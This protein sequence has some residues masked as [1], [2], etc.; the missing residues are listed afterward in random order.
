MSQDLTAKNLE[1]AWK[2]ELDVLKKKYDRQA[3]AVHRRNELI[4]KNQDKIKNLM[5]NFTSQKNSQENVQTILSPILKEQQKLFKQL[6]CLETKVGKQIEDNKGDDQVQN[7]LEMFLL[8]N[9][10]NTQISLLDQEI[11]EI[12]QALDP[13]KEDTFDMQKGSSRNH[14]DDQYLFIDR[15]ALN[16]RLPHSKDQQSLSS[17]ADSV[18]TLDNEVQNNLSQIGTTQKLDKQIE[19]AQNNNEKDGGQRKKQINQEQNPYNV[20]ANVKS[21]G[22]NVFDDLTPAAGGSNLFGG[23]SSSSGGSLFNTQSSTNGEKNIL[24]VQTA[25][26]NTFSGFG[27]TG[28]NLFG[29]QAQTTGGLFSN[30]VQSGTSKL[31][32]NQSQSSGGNLFG[33]QS[34]SI[35]GNLFGNQGQSNPFQNQSQSSTNKLFNN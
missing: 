9:A 33:N 19:I 29:S 27:Q 31:F 16:E 34:Q 13:N 24:G 4:M 2:D 12:Q 11:N 5:E 15:E 32:G 6:E 17:V 7:R 23:Q 20:E 22:I 10:I 8:A 26:T 18:T 35:G 30:Q 21:T 28:G 3:E 25:A 1:E 14:T